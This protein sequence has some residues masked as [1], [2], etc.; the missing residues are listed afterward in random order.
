MFPSDP[1]RHHRIKKIVIGIIIVPIVL[2]LALI[3][4]MFVANVFERGRQIDSGNFSLPVNQ[5]TALTPN[6]LYVGQQKTLIEGVGTESF[7]AT[8]PKVTIV[9]FADFSCP[10]CQSSFRALREIGTRYKDSVKIIFRDWPGHQY[11]IEL[12][13][14]AYCAGE[15]GRFWEMHDKLYENQTADLG[16][17][18]NNIATLAAAIGV[19]NTQF[20]E[21]FDTKKYLALIQQN[22]NDSQTLEVRG[23]PTWFINGTK[24][25]GELNSADKIETLI[26]PY[27]K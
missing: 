18:K 5:Q 7:G 25:E 17:D 8:N 16:A 12:A 3:I 20:Q 11:S 10:Y 27:V 23:T 1:V 13:L 6:N 24:V 9:E 2:F 21:C 14:A 15:Q 19:Y 4:V 26:S 22:V